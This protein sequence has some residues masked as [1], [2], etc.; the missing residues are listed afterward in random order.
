[1]APTEELSVTWRDEVAKGSTEHLP[2]DLC[3]QS[4]APV[5]RSTVLMGSP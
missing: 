5:S 2:Y 4:D 1:M 3:H